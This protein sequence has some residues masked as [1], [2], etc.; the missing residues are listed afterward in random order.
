MALVI[1]YGRLSVVLMLAVFILAGGLLYVAMYPSLPDACYLLYKD[2]VFKFYP[3]DVYA[4]L[5][6]TTKT[7]FRA[8]VQKN[9]TQIIEYIEP[10]NLSNYWK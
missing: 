8:C 3:D 2:E 9:G 6:Q 10:G 4:S 1:N 7:C 5:N